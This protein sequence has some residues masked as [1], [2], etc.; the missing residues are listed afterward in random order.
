MKDTTFSRI[1]FLIIILICLFLFS[2][3]AVYSGSGQYAVADEFYFVKR[4]L[5]WYIV[6]FLMLIMVAWFDYELLEKWA[7]P[8]YLI[9]VLMLVYVQL[10]GTV[11]NGSQRWIDL[12]IFQLQPSEFMKLFLI[13][14]IAVL[15][16]KAGSKRLSFI[17]SIPVVLKVS[18]A[19]VIPLF[20][21]L[22][23]P[24]LGSGLMIVASTLTFLFVSHIST[25]M[26][27]L[28][29]VSL[30]A[31]IILLI[32]LYYLN[33]ELFSRFFQDHQLS[34]IYGWLNPN[35]FASD[36]GY[37]LKQAI[38]G[39]GSGQLTGNGFNQGVQV[40]NGQIPEA[41]TDF[42]FT[43]IGEEFGFI[44][45]SIL[46]LLYFLLIYQIMRTSFH[47]GSLF[48]VYLCIGISGLMAFQI[49]QNIAM[50]VGLMPITGI[51]LPFLSYGGS[52]L[53][54]NLIALGIIASIRIRS[55]RRYVFGKNVLT[56]GD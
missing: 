7:F 3:V 12:G 1:R 42:I 38:L 45:A 14:Y 21:V 49:F 48:G 18:I 10:F 36:Y 51:A 26:L 54:T 39:I 46:L 40:Q 47:S 32:T 27:L 11:K 52:A 4:Q 17:A 20:F 8:M 31:L 2:L 28:L 25:A 43:V 15:L 56:Q 16:K 22:M 34:R 13:L 5:F 44:G 33:F 55:N 30:I 9:G 29:T 24:D 50:T 37:Q 53:L 35:E 41:H 19:T 23:Q 6:G